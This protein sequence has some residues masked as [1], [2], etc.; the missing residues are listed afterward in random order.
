MLAPS[1]DCTLSIGVEKLPMSRRTKFVLLCSAA[2]FSFG[3]FAQNCPSGNCLTIKLSNGMSWTWD[4]PVSV[5]EFR[6]GKTVLL[7]VGETDSCT[8]T[9]DTPAPTGG[10]P[11]NAVCNRNGQPC[12]SGTM[13]PPQISF[14]GG[15]TQ[16]TFTVT[17]L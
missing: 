16:T 1:S 6:C 2:L 14:P 4:L 7:N 15:A 11:V 10:L 8:V 13:A 9:L 12:P 5:K 17:R 3:L